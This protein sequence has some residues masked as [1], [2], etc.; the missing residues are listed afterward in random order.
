V[1]WFKVDDGLPDH[2]KV[3]AL[4]KDQLAAM[5]LW[6]LVGAWAARY[7]T[8][9]HVPEAIVRRHDPRLRLARKLVAVGLWERDY[10]SVTHELLDGNPHFKYHDWY[11]IQLSQEEVER[12]RE[13]NRERQRR[14]RRR[15]AGLDP[16]DPGP[17]DSPVPEIEEF[18]LDDLAGP[19]AAPWRNGA[20]NALPGALVTDPCPDLTCPT[21]SEDLGG[22][23]PVANARERATPTPHN[24]RCEKPCRRCQAARLAEEAAQR[25]TAERERSDRAAAQAATRRCRWCDADGWR[26]DPDNPHRGPITPATRCNHRPLH[27]IEGAHTA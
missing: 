22:R 20:R 10:S 9:G 16:D 6:T 23:V 19:T 8:G 18:P 13:Q 21:S 24:P 26:I 7:G 1:T 25:A 12:K 2:P 5:G 27:V 15:R 17:G 14:F 4:G 11:D 3:I